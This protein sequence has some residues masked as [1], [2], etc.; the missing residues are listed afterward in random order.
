MEEVSNSKPSFYGRMTLDHH[1]KYP[2]DTDQCQQHNFRP[3]AWVKKCVSD[4]LAKRLQG[5]R[6]WVK[7][8]T[9]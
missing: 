4:D 6:N 2:G 9:K 8:R 7:S 5:K 1:C 3:A